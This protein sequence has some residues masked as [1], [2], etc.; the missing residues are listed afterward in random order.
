[1]T[2]HTH[3]SH[4]KKCELWQFTLTVH[5]TEKRFSESAF[6]KPSSK[7]W[8]G[9]SS[10]LLFKK[11]KGFSLYKKEWTVWTVIFNAILSVNCHSSHFKKSVNCGSH[12]LWT[13]KG[14]SIFNLRVKMVQNLTSQNSTQRV[15]FEV[16]EHKKLALGA[17]WGCLKPVLH[18]I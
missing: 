5:T 12:K 15:I 18:L 2:V 17:F 13:V 8:W 4:C 9:D 10:Q 6:M 14:L 7:R 1:M 3:S 11:R 16:G